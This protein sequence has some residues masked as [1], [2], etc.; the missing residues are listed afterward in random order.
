MK[1]RSDQ[2]GGIG[3]VVIGI[4]LESIKKESVQPKLSNMFYLEKK[5]S[6]D[7]RFRV[8]LIEHSI[9]SDCIGS[10]NGNVASDQVEC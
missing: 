1:R 7:H 10:H 3:Y 8:K 2:D 5:E 6:L 4:F 9:F